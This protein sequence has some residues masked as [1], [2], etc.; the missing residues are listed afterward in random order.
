M[1][2][3]A[4]AFCSTSR[5]VRPSSFSARIDRENLVDQDR[6]KT[7]RWLV[8]QQQP[9]LCHQRAADREHLL[10]AAGQRAGRRLPHRIEH[11]KQGEDARKL[12]FQIGVAARP[13]AEP[14]IVLD[15]QRREHLP[16][17]R[18]LRDAERHPPV[19]G[20]SLDRLAVEA[21]RAAGDRLHAGNGAQQRRLAGAVGA[22]QRHDLAGATSQRDAVQRLDA[23]VGAS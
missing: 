4:L 23:A 2:S 13:G 18:H 5:M 22:E 10:L 17:F 9:R 11:R 16:P 6:R 7:H 12:R 19:R 14:Q 20:Q 15:R 21:D 3:A 8:E 1:A